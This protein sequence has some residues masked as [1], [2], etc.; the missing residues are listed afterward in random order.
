MEEDQINQPAILVVAIPV[1]QFEIRLALDHL[2]TDGTTPVLL[3][4]DL[5]AT[6]RRRLQRPLSVTV[7]EVRLPGRIKGVGV[8]LHLDMALRCDGLPHAD[9]LLTADRIGEPPG[10]PHLMGEVAL[11]D[12]APGFVRVAPSGPPLEPS[13]DDVGEFGERLATNHMTMRVGPTPQNGVEGIDE[14]CRGTPRGSLTEGFDLGD[15]GL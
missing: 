9:D 13:P 2:S 11:G 1:M 14:R 15:E 7:L 8:A 12:P 6:W 5:R 3:S 4:Q 10:F